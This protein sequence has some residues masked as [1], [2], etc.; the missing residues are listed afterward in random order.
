MSAGLGVLTHFS[1]MS[2]GLGVLTHFSQKL[3]PA[4]F[5]AL[6][7]PDRVCCAFDGMVVTAENFERLP[8]VGTFAASAIGQ[9]DAA[10]AVDD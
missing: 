3:P 6:P 2:A 5:G 9:A 4:P 8:A 1:A 7:L 10:D